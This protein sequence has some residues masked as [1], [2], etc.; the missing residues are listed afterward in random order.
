MGRRP[1]SPVAWLGWKAV[2][3]AAGLE[4]LTSIG[5]AAIARR[6]RRRWHGRRSVAWRGRTWRTSGP[7]LDGA[8][9][10]TL[11]DPLHADE[12]PEVC[13]LL[14]AATPPRLLA[15][16][17]GWSQAIDA[18][19]FPGYTWTQ[20]TATRSAHAVFEIG[21]PGGG[22]RVL[23]YRTGGQDWILVGEALLDRRRHFAVECIAEDRR[24]LVAGGGVAAIPLLPASAP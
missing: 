21:L 16:R 10:L 6:L 9:Y 18:L 23:A 12:R 8:D 24:T 13:S 17:P 19:C 7:Y 1:T 14:L 4:S 11:A 3:I 2:S 5:P 15:M 22:A 20:R